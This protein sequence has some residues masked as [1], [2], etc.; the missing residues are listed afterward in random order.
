M[1]VARFTVFRGTWMHAPS[2]PHALRFNS[3]C[4][5]ATCHARYPSLCCKVINRY[6]G[7][8]ATGMEATQR[9]L[10]EVIGL[11]R[12]LTYTRRLS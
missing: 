1:A 11:D 9:M 12:W 6:T 5:R 7:A 4:L 10:L 2:G 8:I 3:Q